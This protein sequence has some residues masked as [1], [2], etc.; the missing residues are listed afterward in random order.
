VFERGALNRVD[1]AKMAS[2]RRLGSNFEEILGKI[3]FLKNKTTALWA[4]AR[5]K[6]KL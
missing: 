6:N 1:N 4:V 5:R 3:P 2:Q